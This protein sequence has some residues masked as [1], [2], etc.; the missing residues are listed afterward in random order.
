MINND[1]KERYFYLMNFFQFIVHYG[2]DFKK[3][4]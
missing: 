1:T 4:S 2:K 3:I